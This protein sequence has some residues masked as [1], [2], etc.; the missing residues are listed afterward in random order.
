MLLPLFFTYILTHPSLLLPLGS[1]FLGNYR[2][3]LPLVFTFFF[4]FV[5]LCSEEVEL[6]PR[7]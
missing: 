4:H 5:L 1:G 3:Q 7:C 6:D 2:P